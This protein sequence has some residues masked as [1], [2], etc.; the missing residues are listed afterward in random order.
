MSGVPGNLAVIGA[1]R[2]MIFC[3]EHPG[4]DEDV[5]LPGLR[6]PKLRR[7]DSVSHDTCKAAR[8]SCPG[9]WRGV[10]AALDILLL[11]A[12]M[13]SM[14]RHEDAG[15]SLKSTVTES[16]HP[17]LLARRLAAFRDHLFDVF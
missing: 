11:A 2:G 4:R 17:A 12:S 14:V 9:V 13:N 3:P 6:L 7:L 10:P 8:S 15:T 16:A 5:I 1:Q